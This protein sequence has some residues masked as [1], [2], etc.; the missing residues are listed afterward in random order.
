MACTLVVVLWASMAAGQARPPYSAQEDCGTC[1]Y[2]SC[3][4]P[5]NCEAGIV[6]DRCGC[7]NL[8]AKTEFEKCDHAQVNSANYLGKCGDNLECR[9]RKDVEAEHDATEAICYCTLSSG[10]M[11]GSDGVTYDNLCQLAAAGVRTNT[12]INVQHKGVCKKAP[13]MVS[14]PEHVKD[15]LGANIALVCE[16]EGY[17]IP[18]VEW[19]WTTVDGDTI[20]LPSDDL[21]VSVNMRGGPERSQVTGWLQIMEVEKK[22]EGDYTCIA[23]NEM[24]VVQATAR[25]NVIQ[26]EL[27]YSKKQ[28][29]N[30]KSINDL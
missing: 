9:I 27:A 20:F 7:C 21:K 8:C 28:R 6:A 17:P 14:E 1:D 12:K 2:A 26:D 13:V 18:S 22:H 15:M 4:Y 19:T 5:Q 30:D 10:V 29:R 24:G 25:V 11:C 3:P 23:Q 16:A